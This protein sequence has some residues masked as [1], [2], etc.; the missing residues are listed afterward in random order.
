MRALI[1]AAL[2]VVLL[3]GCT[4]PGPD[5]DATDP[6]PPGEVESDDCLVG[7]W[8]LDVPAYANESELYVTGLG[9]PIVEFAMDGAGE[10]TFTSDGL[11]SVDIALRTSG[12]LIAGDQRIPVD[13]PSAYTATGDWSRTGENTAQFDNWSRVGE[14]DPLT[15]EVDL[16]ALD[17]TQLAD[18][19]A[20]CSADELYLAGPGVPIG[21][22]W[23]R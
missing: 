9:I 2:V 22:T 21:A 5:P 1:P 8:N 18:I 11:V 10:L 3:A 16:P 19:E 12:V 20:E 4:P 23:H 17:F 13:V 6:R 15:P 7:T 14:T